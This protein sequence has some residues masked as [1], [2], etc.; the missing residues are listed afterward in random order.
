VSLVFA[1]QRGRKFLLELRSTMPN[2]SEVLRFGL[3]E[4]DLAEGVLIKGCGSFGH[5]EVLTLRLTRALDY[6]LWSCDALLV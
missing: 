5:S 3:F 6:P 2:R 4:V 1:G